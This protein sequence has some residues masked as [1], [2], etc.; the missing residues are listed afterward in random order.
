MRGRCGPLVL[1]ALFLIAGNAFGSDLRLLR[2]DGPAADRLASAL[3]H[4]GFDIVEGSITPTRFEVITTVDLTPRI[5]ELG[6]ISTELGQGG[7][8]VPRSSTVPTSDGAPLEEDVASPD[9]ARYDDIVENLQAVA[10]QYPSIARVVDITTDL[11]EQATA[12]GRDIYGLRI[13]ANVDRRE[14]EPSVLFVSAQHAREI[15]TPLITLQAISQLT[16]GYGSMPRSRISSIATRSGWSR[17]GIPTD[18]S[19][20]SRPN[21]SG[22]R[23]SSA[24]Q[25]P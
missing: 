2:I 12:E 8:Y 4:E 10:A 11:G 23:T 24:S 1:A 9:Y 18:M 7:P 5:R 6:L 20:S 22:G 14:D 17:S 16:Q 3:G 15:A 21:N 13:S 19:T 25:R